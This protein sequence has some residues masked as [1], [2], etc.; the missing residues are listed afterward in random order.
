M[1]TAAYILAFIVLLVLA[2]LIGSI[3]FGVVIGKLF[4]G[5]DV[6]QHGSGNVGT[7]NVFRVLGKRAGVAV[8]ILDMLKG[9]IPGVI[10]AWLFHPWFAIFIAAAPVVGHM[11][12]V[13]LRFKGGKGIATGAAAVAALVPLVFL[14]VV[15]VW[16]ILVLTTRYVS[17]A[18]LAA[19]TLVPVLTI[20]FGEPLP[21]QI[22]GVLVA[23][24]IWWAHRGNLKRLRA[25]EENRVRLPWSGGG[26]ATPHGQGGA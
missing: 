11:Y 5:V 21:Y 7:T 18:S 2:Y 8:L 12:S 26:R 24:V 20:A 22:A 23:V 15:S 13:F 1:I 14:I 19:T 9:Y 16:V 4:Y 6:R 25:G 3:P 17:V 10:A